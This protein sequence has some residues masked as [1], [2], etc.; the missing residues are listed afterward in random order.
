MSV[1]ADRQRVIESRAISEV[2]T[3]LRSRGFKKRSDRCFSRILDVDGT[4]IPIRLVI[5]ARYPSSLPEVFVVD[6]GAL[7]RRIPHV[8]ATGKLCPLPNTGILA[9]SSRPGAVASEI[10]DRTEGLLQDGLSGSNEQDFVAEFQA[11]WNAQ[12]ICGF[13]DFIAKVGPP[14]REV[15]LVSYK[16]H[17]SS[18]SRYVAAD[19]VRAARRWLKNQDLTYLAAERG[20]LFHLNR[21]FI[22][23][24]YDQ[25]LQIEEVMDAVRSGSPPAMFNSFLWGWARRSEP[26][27]ILVALP[28]M[29][30]CNWSVCAIRVV[31]KARTALAEGGKIEEHPPARLRSHVQKLRVR[32]CDPSYLLSRTGVSDRMQ[33]KTVLVIGCGAIGSL[34][35]VHLSSMGIARL[36]LVDPDMLKADNVHRHALGFQHVGAPKAKALRD[37]LQ[38]RYPHLDFDY[39]EARFE[40]ILEAEPHLLTEVDLVVVGV[41]EETIELLLNEV[42]RFDVPRIHSWVDPLGLGGHVLVIPPDSGAACYRCLF[43]ED[44]ELG[45]HNRA[46]FVA[47]GQEI[48]QTYA[49]CAGYFTPFSYQDCDQTAI[50]AAKLALESLTGELNTS[51]EL[52]SWFGSSTEARGRGVNL[53]KRVHLFEPG[54]T[55]R[56][57]IRKESSCLCGNWR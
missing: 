31:P 4:R 54:Q 52:L 57:E 44:S 5:P 16:P 34:L 50:Y 42:C 28:I 23:P 53:S 21:P 56:L 43:T 8:E 51:T 29:S 30:D 55:Q 22:P 9:D 47:P 20:S 3:L 11:Y 38:S 13:I 19:T 14:S 18:S 25:V 15:M 32:R 48:Q 37:E 26:F 46:S 27:T 45:L 12:D 17:G 36:L 1:Y 6:R 39:R 49:G 7:P 40:D 24:D 2:E 10:L 33:D 41:G 35:A